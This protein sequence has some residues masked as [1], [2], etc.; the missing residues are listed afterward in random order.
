[1][2]VLT[3]LYLVFKLLGLRL[4]LH[5]LA[6]SKCYE[7]AK[8]K[9]LILE[10]DTHSSCDLFD[11]WNV[12][13]YCKRVAHLHI[14]FEWRCLREIFVSLNFHHKGLIKTLGKML[15]ISLLFLYGLSCH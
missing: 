4:K 14:Y 9:L 8:I 2:L 12:G 7:V 10:G 15:Q 5:Q 3:L 11:Q 1:M 13:Y 6:Q